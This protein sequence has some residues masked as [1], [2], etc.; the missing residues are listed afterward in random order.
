MEETVHIYGE[1]NKA[2]TKK[3]EEVV[4]V[5]DSMTKSV[6]KINE[7]KNTLKDIKEM[8]SSSIDVLEE[9]IIERQEILEK[10]EVS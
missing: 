2:Y 7:Y 9:S 1:L 5:I 3:N 6:S 10:M 8:E 4:K